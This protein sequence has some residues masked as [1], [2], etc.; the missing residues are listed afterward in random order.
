M[1]MN[2]KT[3]RSARKRVVILSLATLALVVG[4]LTAWV[5]VDP[6]GLRLVQMRVDMGDECT[7]FDAAEW[8]G[9]R[10]GSALRLADE[11]IKTPNDDYRAMCFYALGK[12]DSEASTHA[13][14]RLL[15]QSYH[16]DVRLRAAY[17]LARK[18]DSSG[19]AYLRL[20]IKRATHT[21]DIEDLEIARDGLFLL[22]LPE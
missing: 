18:G 3:Y 21:G 17:G 10:G 11:I 5:V 6:V 19:E 15:D 22:G 14:L 12:D 9:E 2:S 4:A 8:V 13:L 16:H 7:Q 1:R 20:T